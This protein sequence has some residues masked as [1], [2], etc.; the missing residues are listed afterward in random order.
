MS[1]IVILGGS[2]FLGRALISELLKDE[3]NYIINFDQNPKTNLY[4]QPNPRLDFFKGNFEEIFSLRTLFEM[5]NI[6]TVIHLVSGLLPGSNKEMFI[7]EMKSVI[8][9]TYSL[10]DLMAEYKI[11]KIV[12]LD[13]KSVV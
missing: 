8:L 5:Y 7:N 13:R 9:P 4:F 12:Y 2:G 1:R 11:P 3:N 10:L 6:D